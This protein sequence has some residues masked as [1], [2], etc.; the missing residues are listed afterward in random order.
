MTEPNTII[1]P[2]GPQATYADLR[3]EV[4]PPVTEQL[5]YLYHNGFDAW[6]VMIANIKNQYP[7]EVE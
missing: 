6:K 1:S 2:A 7:K 4:Y 5:D 3:R